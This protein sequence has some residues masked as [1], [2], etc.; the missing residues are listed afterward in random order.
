MNLQ[1]SAKR[2]GKTIKLTAAL[3]LRGVPIKSHRKLVEL[4]E[5]LQ[6]FNTSA[7]QA[8]DGA[9]RDS[10]EQK[11]ARRAKA[12]AK[13]MEDYQ[14]S[15]DWLLEGSGGIGEAIDFKVVA[16]F[17]D[18]LVVLAK[19]NKNVPKTTKKKK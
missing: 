11:L 8:A 14:K 19:S 5:Q 1:I 18:G 7:Q 15:I 12:N 16:D 9:K 3:V 6:A 2:V 10:P 17:E 4:Q 13:L